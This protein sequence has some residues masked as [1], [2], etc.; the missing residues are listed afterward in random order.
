MKN[1]E[2]NIKNIVSSKLCNSCGACIASCPFKALE[3]NIDNIPIVLDDKCT[4]CGICSKVCAGNNFNFLEIYKEIYN[5]NYDI[6]TTLG[7]YKNAYLSYALKE[8]TREQGTSGGLVKALLISLLETSKIKGAILVSGDETECFKA[9]AIVAKTKSDILNAGKSR[10]SRSLTLDVLKQ[11]ET[12]DGKFALVG[13][14]CQIHALWKIRKLNPKINEK[15]LLT[16][17]LFCHSQIET[18]PERIILKKFNIDKLPVKEYIS[19]F[20]KHPGTPYVR[21][22]NNE[23]RPVYFPKKKFYRPTSHEM[24]NIMYRLYTPKRCMYCF[25]GASELAD[26]SVGDPWFKNINKEHF[27]KIDFKDGYSFVL[28]RTSQGKE[29]I[30]NASENNK[31][32]LKELPKDIADN[33]NKEMLIAKKKR[34]W[35]FIKRENLV[36][37]G[38]Y[39]KLI[40][41]LSKKQILKQKFSNMLY[42]FC[43]YKSIRNFLMKLLLTDFGYV[44]LYLNNLRRR[45]KK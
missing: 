28:A 39:G 34:A 11:L 33:C 45:L 9:K 14:P 23:L 40:P 4:H 22:E 24:L 20:G 5:K 44:L 8:E 2:K 15:I 36:D 7:E 37:F 1:K 3:K 29:L 12:E 38:E 10:Y 16:I 19:R 17:G 32:Y 35:Y 13:L 26:I 18:I 25:D 43:S 42:I 30:E 41:S 21:L 27:N 6:K 31:I